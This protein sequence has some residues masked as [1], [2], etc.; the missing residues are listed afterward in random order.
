MLTFCKKKLKERLNYI[1]LIIPTYTSLNCVF[2]LRIDATFYRC[3][4]WKRLDIAG[5]Y[6]SEENA[7]AIEF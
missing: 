4:R 6:F 7:F 3:V 5:M 2:V 1:K